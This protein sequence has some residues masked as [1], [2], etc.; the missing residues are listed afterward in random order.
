MTCRTEWT[1]L[2]EPVVQQVL[3]V[4]LQ[5][6]RRQ[7]HALICIQLSP[8]QQSP[9]VHQQRRRLAWLGRDAL[10]FGNRLWRPQC[11]LPT[12]KHV[13][14][15]L[16][17]AYSVGGEHDQGHA[18]RQAID[19]SAT[20]S[21][22]HQLSSIVLRASLNSFK[23]RASKCPNEEALSQETAL[24]SFMSHTTRIM[25][26]IVASNPLFPARSIIPVVRYDTIG[27]TLRICHC[28]AQPANVA[29]TLSMFK[30]R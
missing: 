28:D 29:A 11:T 13:L 26:P 15:I 25:L 4:L 5:D 8:C 21:A 24:R 10:E 3:L 7:L 9:K 22:V 23:N 2:L 6:Q 27:P 1:N 18:R 16:Q 19:T 30:K 14:P 20:P 17:N 12:P